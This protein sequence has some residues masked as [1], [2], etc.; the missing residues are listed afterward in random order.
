[1]LAYLSPD[2]GSRHHNEYQSNI[3]NSLEF[4]LNLPIRNM[5]HLFESSTILFTSIQE[6]YSFREN[7][8]IIMP[9][10]KL[11]LV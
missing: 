2:E 10:T 1:M 11:S 3:F 4:N 7:N 5:L 9:F 6:Q 8:L